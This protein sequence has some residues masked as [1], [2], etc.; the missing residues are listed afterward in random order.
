M[1]WE[2]PF[3]IC[4]R[5]DPRAKIWLWASL[6][7]AGLLLPPGWWLGCY[8]A[9]L[10][11]AVAPALKAFRACVRFGTR[12]VLPTMVMLIVVYGFL[13]PSNDNSPRDSLTV[14]SCLLSGMAKGAT[15]GARLMIIGAAT[16]LFVSTTP[17]LQFAAGLRA[18]RLPPALVAVF[19]S[20]MNMHAVV[21]RKIRQILDAQRSRGLRCKGLFGRFRMYIPVLRPLLFGM[22]IGAIERSCLWRSRHYLDATSAQTLQFST[23]DI[24]AFCTGIVLVSGAGAARWIF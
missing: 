21:V 20:S 2:S 13:I 23:A 18:M 19:V 9:T 11:G 3:K 14:T 24:A 10:V 15:I 16:L 1:P 22:L 17:Q 7:T 6:I 4:S 8:V 5:V 12:I